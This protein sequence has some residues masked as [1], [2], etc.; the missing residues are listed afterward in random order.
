V[1]RIILGVGGGIAA[2]KMPAA[3]RAW[4]AAG[5]TV[6]VVPTPA[7]L[8]FVGAAVWEAISGEPAVAGIFD[9]GA[10]HVG[11]GR[12]ADLVVVAPATA[13]LLARIA[14][15]L[16]DD[17][18][19]ATVLA[20]SAPLL[21]APAMHG[22]MWRA[23][24]T[25]A[26]VATLTARGVHFI[27]P[28]RGRLAGPDSDIGRMAEPDQI[29]AAASALLRAD[30]DGP[31]AGR[32]VVVTAGGTREPIDPVRFIGNRSSG[33]QGVALAEAA[34][35]LGAS[36]ELIAANLEVSAPPAARWDRTDVATASQ[37]R[38][39]TLA[40]AGGADI[41]IMAAAVADF[42]PAVLA[43]V[44]IKRAG[45]ERLTLELA[46]TA[47]ILAELV[48]A[49]R[50]GQVIVGF[51]AETGDDAAGVLALGQAK[52]CAKGADLIAL[53]DVSGGRVF[54]AQDSAVWL[55]DAAGQVV[56]E[57]RGGK[58]EVADAIMSAVAA[59]LPAR[60]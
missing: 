50:P 34:E 44:K 3:V 53:N 12:S 19:T 43:D 45:R 30:D 55:L 56:G 52:A 2:Y 21:L 22:N 59:R 49:R 32:R 41:V 47:D 57:A 26:N 24:A 18:L 38:E 48:A 23:P 15:G 42:T 16:A 6:R 60:D 29:A 14:A 33:R 37:L 9:D 17:L 27:G 20:S 5:H 40:A 46:P 7:A 1:A 39:A 31:L 51:A 8:R 4:R 11:L 13:D 10:N 54:G 36:V 28:E 35:A 25:S 58:R